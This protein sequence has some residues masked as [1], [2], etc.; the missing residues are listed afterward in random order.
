MNVNSNIVEDMQTITFPLWFDASNMNQYFLDVRFV[1]DFIVLKQVHINNTSATQDT[2]GMYIVKSDIL[3]D[4]SVVIS[5]G[6][7]T[8][9][10]YNVDIEFFNRS[11]ALVTGTKTFYLYNVLGAS[12]SNLADLNILLSLTFQFIKFKKPQKSAQ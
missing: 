12:V 6:S 2:T 3:S 5:L 11:S 1:P 9:V 4:N 7:T 10:S 8:D